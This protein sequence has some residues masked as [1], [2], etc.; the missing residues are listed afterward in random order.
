M[1]FRS[2][3]LKFSFITF[4]LLEISLSSVIAKEH[5]PIVITETPKYVVISK[6]IT[7]DRDGKQMKATLTRPQDLMGKLPL[8]ALFHGFTGQRHEMTIAGTNE[9]MFGHAAIQFSQHGLVTL[10]IDFIGSGE[11]QGNWADTTFSSQI[12]DARAALRYMSGQAFVDPDRIAVL[13]LSQGGLV[14]A[15]TASRDS[16]VR[17]AILWSPVA[18]P[19]DTYSQLLGRDTVLAGLKNKEKPTTAKLPWGATTTLKHTFYNE[20]FLADPVAEISSFKGNLLVVVGIK[21]FIVAPQPHYGQ[22]YLRYHKGS[23]GAKNK[24][25][26]LDADHMLNIL[27]KDHSEYN[28]AVSISLDFLRDTL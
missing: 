17:T 24:L 25:L 1:K 2:T 5:N 8:V 9:T 13:G 4:F 6:D 22:K 27:T 11:S 10:R 23:I 14:A 18:D 20:L 15:S 21:D 26:V 16:L 12:A 7:I 28:K 19:A 3:F